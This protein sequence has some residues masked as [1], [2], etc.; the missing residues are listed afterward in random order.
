[1][2]NPNIVYGRLSESVH[3]SGYSLE[4]AIW[5][6]EWLLE[7]NRWKNVGSGYDDIEEFIK[8]LNFSE[9][10]IVIE[11]RKK[12]VQKL[13]ELKAS[14][15]AIARM[16]G[17]SHTTIQNDTGNNM[18]LE[19][20]ITTENENV[21]NEY[22]TNVLPSEIPGFAVSGQKEVRQQ[23]RIKQKLEIKKSGPASKAKTRI[24]LKIIRMNYSDKLQDPRWQ[25]IRDRILL[26]DW[27]EC[28]RCESTENLHVHHKCYVVGKEPWEYNYSQLITLCKN[29]H[30]S[31][32]LIMRGDDFREYG[33]IIM[34]KF[35]RGRLQERPF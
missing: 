28:Q 7:D 16:L 5:E 34:E 2:E 22:Y 13:D 35:Y 1:M 14:Q 10:K 31:A 8:T 33:M 15:R 19:E 12:I 23:K 24:N 18:P 17:L 29:C 30:E 4:R 11:Q 25:E 9:F 21:I 32:H 6:F 27:N 20:K 26:R 3:I